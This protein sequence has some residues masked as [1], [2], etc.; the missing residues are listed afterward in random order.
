[1]FENRRKYRRFF[2]FFQ[3][4]I[5]IFFG[6]RYNGLCEIQRK[7]RKLKA[8]EQSRYGAREKSVRRSLQI[9]S[10]GDH[11]NARLFRGGRVHHGGVQL[12]RVVLSRAKERGRLL[13]SRLRR[14][15]PVGTRQYICEYR[16][17][18]LGGRQGREHHHA[19]F[20]GHLFRHRMEFGNAYGRAQ[21]RQRLYVFGGRA[22]GR[23][24]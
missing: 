24:L 18:V 5:Y 12:S 17:G 1:M 2:R 20:H 7:I 8:H 15:Q 11:F 22:L 10:G 9:Q 6:I 23:E 4:V 13:L 19:V 21:V 16:R 3:K 14:E